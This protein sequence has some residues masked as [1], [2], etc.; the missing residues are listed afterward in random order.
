MKHFVYS[1]TYALHYFRYLENPEFHSVIY[2][3]SDVE[4]MH[5]HG[6]HCGVRDDVERRMRETQGRAVPLE[7]EQLTYQS[8]FARYRRSA[9]D[10]TSDQTICRL[11]MQVSYT[12]LA[13][14]W[15]NSSNLQ[16]S[17]LNE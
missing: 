2:K 17:L 9:T 11:F 1:I 10:P 8:A 12:L 14:E 5:P 3:S 13:Q 15:K 6:S 7:E 16:S 4:N